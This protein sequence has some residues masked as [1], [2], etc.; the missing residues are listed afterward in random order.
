[1]SYVTDM[2]ICVTITN[3][4]NLLVKKGNFIIKIGVLNT[5]GQ[6]EELYTATEEQKHTENTQHGY[7]T[8]TCVCISTILNIILSPLAQRGHEAL[9][10]PAQLQQLETRLKH[11]QSFWL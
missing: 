4:N 7:A 3:E 2:W 10:P 9:E 6:S 1:M 8:I 5:A 11:I